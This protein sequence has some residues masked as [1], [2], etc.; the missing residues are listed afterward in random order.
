MTNRINLEEDHNE[1][2]KAASLPPAPKFTR[3]KR[4]PVGQRSKMKWDCPGNDVEW[5]YRVVNDVENRVQEFIE[6]GYEIVTGDHDLTSPEVGDPSQLGSACRKYVGGGTHGVLMRIRKDW[7]DEDQKTKMNLVDNTEKSMEPA[8]R[9]E[10]GGKAYG[11][12]IKIER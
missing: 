10:I 2:P 5:H 12:G 3:P 4:T 11:D 9:A 6:G 1:Q 8:A 7:Y